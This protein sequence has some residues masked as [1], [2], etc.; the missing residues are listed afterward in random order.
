MFVIEES[1][2]QSLHLKT[3]LDGKVVRALLYVTRATR[4]KRMQQIAHFKK[5][6]QNRASQT[7]TVVML[8]KNNRQ[9]KHPI[10]QIFYT[11]KRRVTLR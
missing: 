3:I 2:V 1:S 8:P 11:R 4:K 5:P 9:I 7:P 6:I 10:R